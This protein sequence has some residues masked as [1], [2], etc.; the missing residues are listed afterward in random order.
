MVNTRHN[1]LEYSKD[2]GSF[3]GDTILLLIVERPVEAI[4]IQ[5]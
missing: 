4:Q 5:I 3:L 1:A 2:D